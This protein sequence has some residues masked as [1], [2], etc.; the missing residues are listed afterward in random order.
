MVY[1]T[2]YAIVSFRI[3]R[4]FTLATGDN[5]EIAD[6]GKHARLPL[7]SY[8]GHRSKNR[9]FQILFETNFSYGLEH[10]LFN[11]TIYDRAALNRGSWREL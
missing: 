11:G 10:G 3:A 6:M 1:D 4:L 7:A 8:L 9:Y 2:G 5:F